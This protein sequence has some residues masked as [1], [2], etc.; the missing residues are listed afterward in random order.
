MSSRETDCFLRMGTFFPS[1]L[2][3]LTNKPNV[4]IIGNWPSSGLINE[5]KK[6]KAS[7]ADCVYR[8]PKQI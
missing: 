3:I 5:K 4:E 1:T 7:N 8:L 2:L 6:K